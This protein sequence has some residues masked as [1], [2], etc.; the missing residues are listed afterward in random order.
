MLCRFCENN[1]VG[2]YRIVLSDPCDP[3]FVL[4][5]SRD[6]VLKLLVFGWFNC[7]PFLV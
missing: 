6:D 1:G 7:Y 3:D 5:M 4:V 2:R